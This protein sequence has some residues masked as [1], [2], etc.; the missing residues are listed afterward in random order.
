MS[1]KHLFDK[2]SPS[3]NLS[4]TMPHYPA[5][6]FRELQ[7]PIDNTNSEREQWRRDFAGKLFLDQIINWIRTE[8]PHAVTTM[9]KDAVKWTDLLLEALEAKK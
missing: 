2:I 1:D 4:D 8:E 7:K 9:A 6:E 3:D 5:G